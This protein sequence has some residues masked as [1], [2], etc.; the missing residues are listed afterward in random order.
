MDVDLRDLAGGKSRFT[1]LDF[2][3]WTSKERPFHCKLEEGVLYC[4]RQK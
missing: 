3:F 2:R 4:E 1:A